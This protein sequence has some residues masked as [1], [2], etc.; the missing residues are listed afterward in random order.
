[1]GKEA[2]WMK[3]AQTAIPISQT[4]PNANIAD[5]YQQHKNQNN[6]S[7]QQPQPQQ[8][9]PQQQPKQMQIFNQNYQGLMRAL[10]ALRPD[11]QNQASAAFSNAFNSLQAVLAD[12]NSWM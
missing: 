12:P 1:M 3:K 10:N 11:V 2:G 5:V 6:P 8:A 7:V 9:Q 4:G